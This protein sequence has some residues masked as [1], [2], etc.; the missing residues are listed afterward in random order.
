MAQPLVLR[1]LS[2]WATRLLAQ[3]AV[4]RLLRA[5]AAPWGR[6]LLFSIFFFLL[7]WLMYSTVWQQLTAPTPLPSGVSDQYPYLHTN[8]IREITT[9]RLERL[10]A[11]ALEVVSVTSA[12]QAPVTL[13]P[14][15]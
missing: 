9:R 11:P 10:G 2:F 3:Q 14:V 8:S 6:L 5:L 7:V 4:W 13:V 1:K 12:V 15:P